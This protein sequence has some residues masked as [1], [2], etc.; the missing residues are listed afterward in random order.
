MAKKSAL[1]KA[2]EPGKAMDQRP[3][4]PARRA[5]SSKKKFEGGELLG[6]IWHAGKNYGPGDEEAFS[7]LPITDEFKQILANKG[8]LTG[9][10]TSEPE[11]EEEPEEE[12]PAEK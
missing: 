2:G 3:D 8:Q 11:Y 9:F 12:T 6:T 10:G 4:R 7:K 5:K 1:K